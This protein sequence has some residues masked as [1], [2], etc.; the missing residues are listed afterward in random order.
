MTFSSKTGKGVA[1]VPTGFAIHQMKREP[2]F[3]SEVRAPDGYDLLEHDFAGQEYR[4][5]AVESKDP[6]MLGLC[7]PGEDPH[8]YMAAMI[9]AEDYPLLRGLVED[10]D[11]VAL[12]K[13]KF[14]KV[15]NLSCQ[16]RTSP[17]T[18]QRVSR[19]QHNLN[20]SLDDAERIQGTYIRTYKRV[21]DY[22]RDQIRKGRK[23]G[24]IE[25]LA[26]RRVQLTTPW[27][28]ELRWGLESAAINSPIQGVGAD[29]KYLGMAVLRDYLPTV[30][31][32]FYFDLHDGLY[33][34]V[35]THKSEKAAV[36]IRTLL[37][38]LPYA[39]A[40]GVRLPIAFPVDAKRGP[41]WGELRKV[42]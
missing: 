7:E 9:Y 6:I 25:T 11:P 39:K 29:Q 22:W 40:W 17:P 14:G 21:P 26:G 20:I 2:E 37:S 3:R 19:T 31:G 18:L 8:A 4:W 35:P 28:N 15:G 38:N 33:S 13:R 42:H 32:R 16:Y 27:P 5:M 10:E 34:V 30:D 23:Q 1:E 41:S 12:K 24:Y 36:E